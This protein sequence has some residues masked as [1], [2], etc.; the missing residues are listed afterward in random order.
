MHAT[1]YTLLIC[2]VLLLGC[3]KVTEPVIEEHTF[4]ITKELLKRVIL[5]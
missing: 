2:F 1:K 5:S 4:N 3:S